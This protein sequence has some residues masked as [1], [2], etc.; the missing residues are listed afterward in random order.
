M[1]PETVEEIRE[2]PRPCPMLDAVEHF[3]ARVLQDALADALAATWRRRAAQMED[4]RPRA[5]DFK[6]K[7]RR[8]DTAQRWLRLTQA[9]KLCRHRADISPLQDHPEVAE[10][11]GSD[12]A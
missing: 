4:A 10:A 3:R 7:A 2:H 6:G 5:G 8:D 9:A 11:M 1:A 12:A